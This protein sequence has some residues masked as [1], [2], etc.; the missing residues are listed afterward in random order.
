MSIHKSLVPRAKLKR[1][2]NVL[3]RWERVARLTKEERW[4]EDDSVFGLPKVRNIIQK[5][6][7]KP[8]KEATA[9]A[10]GAAAPSA[11]GTTAAAPTT[12]KQ[13][14]PAKASAAPAAKKEKAK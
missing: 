4:K 10:E 5:V 14:V 13:T 7:A 6:K 9:T 12:G 2:R 11:T 1:H 8:K 3:T